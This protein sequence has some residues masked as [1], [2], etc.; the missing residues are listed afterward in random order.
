MQIYISKNN[1]QLGPFDEAKVL[2]MLNG[3]QLSA[4]DMAIR[5]GDKDWQ[6]L[7]SFFPN[8]GNA[9]PVAAAVA[10]VKQTAP[11]KSRKGLLLGCGGFLVIA[12]LI[13][14]VLGFL[15]YRNIFPA[16]STED[17]PD[18]VGDLKLANR[19]PPKGNIWGTETNFVGIY[20]DESKTKTVIYMMTVYADETA[21][22]EAMR[23]ELVKTCQTGESPMHFT[24]DKGGAETSQGA[25]CA[26]PLYV[27]KGN[28][29]ATI[30][31]SG[32][33]A[34]TFIE[35]AENLPFNQGAKMT[36]KEDK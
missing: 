10:A 19:Y 32:G 24:F 20:G 25:T 22:K 31:G 34:D 12:L 6:K 23:S 14:G 30:G 1:Q 13:A 16:D 7:G 4:S 35:F 27:Q 3:G 21:A 17:L 15:A 2:E 18:K 26:V 36:R 11:K 8:I 9:A 29:L 28:K 33:N 5:H